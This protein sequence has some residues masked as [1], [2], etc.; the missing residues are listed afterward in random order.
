M[1]SKRAGGAFDPG[2]HAARFA[3]G[4]AGVLQGTHTYVLQDP[5]GN[6]EL[7][8]SVS[9]GLDYAAVGPEHAWL[10][11]SHRAEYA[12][13]DDDAAMAAFRRLGREE[14]ILP[15]LESAHAVAYACT[16]APTMTRDQVLL[17]NL[18]GRGD[19]DVHSVEKA[20]SPI[21]AGLM[22]RLQQSF[23]RMKAAG[24]GGLVAYLTA[25]DPDPDTS[26]AVI[27]AVARAGADVVEI[28]VPFSDPLA[29]GPVIQRAI[30]RALARGM[31]LRRLARAGAE[32]AGRASRHQSCCSPTPTRCCAW[33]RRRSPVRRLTP[34]STAC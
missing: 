29:D 18:S 20:H 23:E 8:H 22:S 17:V 1:A 13:V 31:T 9:A 26:A 6:I 11:D 25:G 24:R 14:G 7:T 19:K 16:L 30:E 3:G 27:T 34:A 12:W 28:G 15:A 33:A 32:G 10:H 21:G 5:D 2:E 4:S